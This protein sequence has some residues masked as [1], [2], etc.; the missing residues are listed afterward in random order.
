MI[1]KVSVTGKPGELGDNADFVVH[2]F[3]RAGARL[4]LQLE[5]H[6]DIRMLQTKWTGRSA[7]SSKASFK[8]RP[9]KVWRNH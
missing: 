9:W 4:V 1:G 2:A 3:I 8:F 6:L 5:K 7:I